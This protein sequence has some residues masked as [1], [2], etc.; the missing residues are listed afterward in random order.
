MGKARSLHELRNELRSEGHCQPCQNTSR[1]ECRR[2]HCSWNKLCSISQRASSE[3]CSDNEEIPSNETH[4]GSSIA[5]EC[6]QNIMVPRAEEGWA[7][8]TNSPAIGKGVPPDLNP[9]LA[10]CKFLMNVTNPLY[11]FAP[12]GD[13]SIIYVAE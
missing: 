6:I 2:K 3:P 10:L 12:T 13:G 1:P 11:R 9:P 4:L 5:R 7:T 8:N